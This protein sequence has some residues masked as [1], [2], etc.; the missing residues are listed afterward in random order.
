MTLPIDLIPGTRPPRFRW[1]QTVTT[2]AGDRVVNYEGV[3][4]PAAEEAVAQLIALAKTQ[5]KRLDEALRLVAEMSEK[6]RQGSLQ[7]ELGQRTESPA[8]SAPQPVSSSKKGR[9]TG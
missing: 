1:R 2:P 8:V 5:A 6:M 4:P 3:L 9:G 7:Q